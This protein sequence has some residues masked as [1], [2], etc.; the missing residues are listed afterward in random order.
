MQAQQNLAISVTAE[1]LSSPN[2]TDE[3]IPNQL[4][5][6]NI[7]PRLVKKFSQATFD[8]WFSSLKPMGMTKTTFYIGAPNN[9]LADIIMKMYTS[10][11]SQIIHEITGKQ[12]LIG[13]E[14]IQKTSPLPNNPQQTNTNTPPK[15]TTLPLNTKPVDKPVDSPVKTTYTIPAN[16]TYSQTTTQI[17][18]PSNTNIK[19][20]HLLPD[21]SF[22]FNNFVEGEDNEFAKS[23]ALNVAQSKNIKYNPLVI[24]GGTGVGK[25]HLLN[26]IGN[27]ILKNNPS[28][29]VAYAPSEKFTNELL[30]SLYTKNTSAFRN[31]YRKVNALLLDDIQFLMEKERTQEEFFHT[32]NDLI[33]EDC[34]VVITSDRPPKELTK[35]TSRLQSRLQGGLIVDIKK[36]N[37][38]TRLGILHSMLNA[39]HVPSDKIE[40]GALEE[41]AKDIKSN[42]RELK[43]FVN[44]IAAYY[45]ITNK[46]ISVS[47][48]KSLLGEYFGTTDSNLSYT[49][50]IRQVE[51]QYKL[52]SN[53][54]VSKSRNKNVTLPRQI[55]MYL[56]R[57]KLNLSYPKIGSIFGR[58][59]ATVIHNVKI[60]EENKD[61][62]NFL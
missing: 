57:T 1:D 31:K 12:Y 20:P 27:E 49:D 47:Y 23:A 19:N 55:A 45:D 42:T 56:C 61:I 34:L 17:T 18:E 16:I 24:Y 30:E 62:I 21:P 3:R 25:T 8:A 7:L 51:Q 14:I 13:V 40:P 38:S 50:I 52:P 36:P 11:L 28:Y 32:F 59:H 48:I 15:T 22:T 60:I 37:L 58:S 54:L 33:A 39:L 53:S 46:P 35:L 29:I 6:N 2:T 41:L 26:A 9:I 44:K 4:I 5:W 43:G 10:T